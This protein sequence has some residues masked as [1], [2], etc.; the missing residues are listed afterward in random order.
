VENELKRKKY[1]LRPFIIATLR[2]ASLR[3][4]ARNE[5]KTRAR[6]ERGLYQCNVCKGT[7]GTKEI[8]LDHINPV[9]DTKLG[10]TNWDDYITRLFV[11]PEQYQTLCTQCHSSKTLLET[12]MRKY[13]KKEKKKLEK[14]KKGK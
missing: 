11:E 2:R 7:F 6:I 4:W 13:Y 14:K 10:F 8:H 5:A 3:W 1:N 9:L 12:E